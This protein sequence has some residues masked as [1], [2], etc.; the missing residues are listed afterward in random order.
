MNTKTLPQIADYP[1]PSNEELECLFLYEVISDKDALRECMRIVS[2]DFFFST[3]TWKI[4]S[5]I[6]KKY[7]EHEVIDFQ[8]MFASCD[9]TF[10]RTKIIAQAGN[11]S[12]DIVD[13][14]AHAKTLKNLYEQRMMYFSAIDALGK[15]GR[16]MN[17]E[18]IK[19]AMVAYQDKIRA[20]IKD[21]GKMVG[22]A[23]AF[24]E[25]AEDLQKLDNHIP[26][27]IN[28]LDYI[29][30][31]GYEGG[32]LVI[33]AARPS[34]GKTTI[35]LQMAYHA[36]R[37]GKKVA[38]YS[39]EMT[40]KEIARKLVI[41]SGI[42]NPIDIYRKQVNWENYDDAVRVLTND[43]LLLCDKFRSAE[44]IIGSIRDLVDA[45]QCDIAYIDYLG[46]VEARM[47]RGKTFAQVIGEITRALKICAMDCDIPIVLLCQ[48]NR[49]V[50]GQQRSPQLHDLR[51]S[52]SIEQDA[53]KVLMMERP[54]TLSDDL[55]RIDLWVRKNRG[56]KAGELCFHLVGD[57]NYANFREE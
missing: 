51:D 15:I 47:T 6:E 16:G 43:N 14:I 41:N 29:F 40:N 28:N 38:F 23:D 34:V 37:V 27:G 12:G 50:M 35:G 4:W 8:T 53:D 2:K 32:N 1:I 26:T 20:T 55:P 17:T 57:N 3:D 10:F 39:L 9:K 33:L 54:Q 46:L 7:T 22:L 5:I 18:V 24:N 36:S 49:D 48:L 45:N 30:Y 13:T 56:G 31:G 21:N 19:D 11:E 42:V 44:Q 52:G 25:V